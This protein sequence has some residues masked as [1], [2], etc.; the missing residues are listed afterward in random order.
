MQIDTSHYVPV[1]KAKAGEF[2]ALQELAAETRAG[3]TPLMEIVAVPWDYENEE[4]A[5]TI[6]AH[7]EPLPQKILN[8][9]GNERPLFTDLF[10]VEDEGPLAD[11]NDVMTSFCESCRQAGILVIPVTGLSRNPDYQAAVANT[12]ATDNRGACIR[13]TT[14]DLSAG[15][16]PVQD[17]EALLSELGVAPERVDMILDL[18]PVAEHLL[19][20]YRMA[21]PT[22][23]QAIAAAGA[24]R[25]L[26]LTASAFPVDL[27]NFVKDSI[28]VT[29]RTEWTLWQHLQGLAGGISRMPAF[30]DYAIAH[31]DQLEI[32]PRMIRMSH[33][34]RYA[35]D[36]EWIVVKGH[37]HKKG[38]PPQYQALSQQLMSRPRWCGPDFSWGDLFI[39]ECASGKS[40][41]GN[42][43]TWR[44]VG[45]NHHLTFVAQQIA[46]LHAP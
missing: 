27:S 22:F 29:S 45:T 17:V 14:D 36:T 3:L 31:P 12:V 23:I 43:T 40:G 44:A 35:V 32:D 15:V 4:P 25:S 30:G 6:D 5:K 13:L 41:P 1:L 26:V 8:A 37:A 21:V 34:I 10:M 24:W 2:K 46:N 16:F 28:S 9:W 38:D 20:S 18:G 33:S 39:S 7:L 42:A 19:G 11:G